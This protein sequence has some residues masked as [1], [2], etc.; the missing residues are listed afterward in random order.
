[1]RLRESEV[2]MNKIDGPR[3]H[4]YIKCRETHRIQEILT[5]TQ[6]QEDFR[7]E[8]REISKVRIEAVGLGM[9]RARV[10]NLP[11]EVAYRTLKMALGMYGEVR[12]IHAETWSNAYRYPV[13]NGIRVVVM[14]LVEHI[15][16]HMVVAGHRTLVSYE[17]Q[18]TTT[19]AM[20]RAI[21]TQR[22]LIGDRRG[23][24]TDRRPWRHGRKGRRW[25]PLWS[26]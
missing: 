14:T 25:G 26:N 8:N 22:A 19:V 21:C 24:R 17:G 23:Q 3:R 11:T 4:V 6:G 9:R 12:D 15:P 16:S 20:N 10:A 18:P 7:H 1:M 13:A 5:A 2:M